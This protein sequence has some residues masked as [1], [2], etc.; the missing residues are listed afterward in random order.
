ML[1][2]VWSSEM[3]TGVVLVDAIRHDLWETLSHLRR[4]PEWEFPSRYAELTTKLECVF[5][6]EEGWMDEMNNPL[7][8][9]H[10]EQHARVLSGLHHVH[11][12]V[13]AGNIALGREVVECLLPRWLEFHMGTM[14]MALAQDMEISS[15]V[16]SPKN[17]AQHEVGIH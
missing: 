13:L 12:E 14:D 6:R 15:R 5:S 1:Q 10:R 8:K 2:S 7:L 11:A 4:T 3:S 17:S 16:P 9:Q